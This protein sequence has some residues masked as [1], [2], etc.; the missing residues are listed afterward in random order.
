MVLAALTAAAMTV[1]VLRLK[2]SVSADRPV[3]ASVG[4]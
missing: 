4:A 3:E 2:R 1:V